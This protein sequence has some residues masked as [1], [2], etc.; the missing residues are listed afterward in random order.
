MKPMKY[1]GYLEAEKGKY[2]TFIEKV[3][4]DDSPLHVYQTVWKLANKKDRLGFIYA[5]VKPNVFKQ[6]AVIV[7][8]EYW[9]INCG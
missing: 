6:V 5:E 1:I 3:I 9:E 4:E 7:P 8:I 2:M